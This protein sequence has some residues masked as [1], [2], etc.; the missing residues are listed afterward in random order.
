MKTLRVWLLVPWLLVAVVQ[1]QHIPRAEP[2]EVAS[3]LRLLAAWIESQ[4]AYRGLPGM[5]IGIVF[6]QP[7]M[8]SRGFAYSDVEKK[9]PAPP[10]TIYR[11][12]SVTKL[13]T[14]PAIMPRRDA[15]R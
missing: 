5:S 7:R 11:I 9:I 4:M 10:T 12:A 15:G 13:L 8:W 2:P 3:S 1:A 14:A 6:D